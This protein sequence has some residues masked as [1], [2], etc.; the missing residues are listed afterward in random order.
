MR[1]FTIVLLVLALIPCNAQTRRQLR[2]QND[3]LQLRVA[4]LEAELASYKAVE[5]HLSGENENK[6]SFALEDYSTS[7]SSGLSRS[8][9]SDSLMAWYMHR[10]SRNASR[11]QYNMDGRSGHHA[12]A[13]SA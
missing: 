12:Y 8:S 10:A 13:P 7:S 3:T 9:Q 2:A 11:E 6:V 4:A 1:R 5:E